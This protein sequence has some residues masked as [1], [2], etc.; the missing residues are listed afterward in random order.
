MAELVSD[1]LWPEAGALAV[2]GSG[3]TL[4]V[5]LGVKV[6]VTVAVTVVGAAAGPDTLLGGGVAEIVS[7]DDVTSPISIP[8][9]TFAQSKISDGI[10]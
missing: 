5:K 1:A 6:I 7:D 2:S 10:L 4:G 3:G 9:W 8:S